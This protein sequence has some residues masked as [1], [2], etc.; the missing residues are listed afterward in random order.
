MS[1][2]D[3]YRY[4]RNPRYNPSRDIHIPGDGDKYDSLGSY[5][6]DL[7]SVN[8]NKNKNKISK[9]LSEKSHCFEQAV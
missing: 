6:D 9:N 1:K 7:A 8:P 2:A 5:Y 4:H 3:L